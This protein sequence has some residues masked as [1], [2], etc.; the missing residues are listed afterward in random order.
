MK[1]ILIIEDEKIL[2]DLLQK[3]LTNEGYAVLTAADG[4]EG[5][6]QIKENKPNL[7]L[8]DILMPKKG[9]FE[10]MRDMAEDPEIKD[11][12][13]IIISN[14]GQPVELEKAKKMGA[15]DCLVKAEFNPQEVIE[16]VREQIGE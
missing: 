6:K 16:K 4:E 1:K 15:K 11:I 12:P 13:V 10:V 5:V 9:G 8:L 3:K 2:S 14:S 7:I